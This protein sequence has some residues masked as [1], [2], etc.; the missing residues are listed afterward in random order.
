MAADDLIELRGLRLA[1][2]VGVLAHEQAQPQP[3]EL[4]LDIHLDLAAAGASDDLGDTVDY[5][6]LC[7]VAEQVVS[8]TRYA[9]LEALAEHLAARAARRRCPHRRRDPRGAQ[10]A[11]ARGPAAQHLRGAHLPG[12]LMVRRAFLGLGSNLG[13]RVGFLRAAVASLP[14]L[15]ATSPVY[16]TEPV[17]GPDDQG[18]YL[19]LVAELHT[20][21]SPRAAPRAA[22]RTSSSRPVVCARSGG[23]RGRSTSTCCWS[24]GWTVDEPDLQVP[25]PRM[26]ERRFVLAPLADL[27]PDLVTPAQVAAARGEVRAL[28]DLAVL[29]G[30]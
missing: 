14:D 19:N 26:G 20:T 5:G 4:D 29:D 7:A 23:G 1:G 24:R 12:A 13:D 9:L 16:E 27:A 8:T 28:G 10:A 6:A 21:L 3:L 30:R 22:A 15:V 25:H 2:I 18:A 11:P 17:G